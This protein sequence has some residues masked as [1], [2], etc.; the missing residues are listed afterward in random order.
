MELNIIFFLSLLQANDKEEKKE[1]S[2]IKELVEKKVTEMQDIFVAKE[3]RIIE[4]YEQVVKVCDLFY[5]WLAWKPSF[6]GKLNFPI[7]VNLH[8]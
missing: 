5:Q 3:G 6:T 7:K 2:E 4:N 1:R 8:K